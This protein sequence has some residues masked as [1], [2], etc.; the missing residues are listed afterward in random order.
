MHTEPA[1]AKRPANQIV[2]FCIFFI[3]FSPVEG[4]SLFDATIA[5]LKIGHSRIAVS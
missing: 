2:T 5:C 1:Q 3:L 4:D